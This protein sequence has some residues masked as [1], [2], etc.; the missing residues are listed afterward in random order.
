MATATESIAQGGKINS[1]F[2]TELKSTAQGRL[3]LAFR[4]PRCQVR[5]DKLHGRGKAETCGATTM[6]GGKG[7]QAKEH[8]RDKGEGGEST[9]STTIGKK[10]RR[11]IGRKTRF[12]VTNGS[13]NYGVDMEDGKKIWGEANSTENGDVLRIPKNITWRKDKF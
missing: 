4:K 12:W 7:P 8:P 2:P 5:L 11:E 6:F 3:L 1:Y 13:T 9:R 10:I